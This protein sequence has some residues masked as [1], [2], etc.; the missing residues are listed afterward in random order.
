MHENLILAAAIVVMVTLAA[1]IVVYLSVMMG[2][3]AW[4][5]GVRYARSEVARKPTQQ[6]E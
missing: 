1:P 4:F 2:T 5:R 3:V 6:K